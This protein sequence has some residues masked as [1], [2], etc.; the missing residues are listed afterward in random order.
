MAEPTDEPA[1]AAGPSAGEDQQVAD[2]E[3]PMRLATVPQQV[4]KIRCMDDPEI[5]ERVL[6]GLLD[7][8]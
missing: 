6:A 2:Q 8:H 1:R 3:L 7:L 4:R 5:L